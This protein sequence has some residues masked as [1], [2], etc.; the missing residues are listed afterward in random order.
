[1]FE[2]RDTERVSLNSDSEGPLNLPLITFVFQV[3]NVLFL[4]ST[5]IGFRTH[6]SQSGPDVCG[7]IP[8]LKKFFNLVKLSLVSKKQNQKPYKYMVSLSGDPFRNIVTGGRE[9]G[10]HGTYLLVEH[11]KT[12]RC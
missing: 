10:S 12:R 1:M 3:T 5:R 9:F 4:K 7:M 6:W 8:V 2:R 11:L